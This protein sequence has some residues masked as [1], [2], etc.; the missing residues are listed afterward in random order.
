ME[1]FEH[2]RVNSDRIVNI[3]NKN[4]TAIDMSEMGTGKTYTALRVAS[5]L[6]KPI[7]V[8]CPKSIISTWVKSIIEFGFKQ[9]FNVTN[10]EQI[11]INKDKKYWKPRGRT[12]DW[13]IDDNTLV[14]F[15]EAHRLKSARSKIAKICQ[16]IE[17]KTLLLSATL[18][19]SPLEMRCAGVLLGLFQWNQFF[20]WIQ[21]NGC[22]KNPRFGG[23]VYRYECDRWRDDVRSYAVS[24]KLSSVKDDMKE[25]LIQNQIVEIENLKLVNSAFE[26]YLELKRLESK[27]SAHIEALQYALQQCEL[28]KVNY[29][30][31]RIVDAHHQGYKVIVF[32]T[33]R[34]SQEI[35]FKELEGCCMRSL[36][37]NGSTVQSM[38]ENAIQAFQGDDLDCLLLTYGTCGEGISLDDK[39][40]GNKRMV[41]L[42]PNW[43]AIKMKQALG[44]AYR[45]STKSDVVQQIIF[46]KGTLEEQVAKKV[47]QKLVAI[48]KL[49]ND[50]LF[51]I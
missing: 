28:E 25:N 43:S 41:M 16:R 12:F 4:Q 30:K 31:E 10:Y 33:Y 15:D 32:L 26:K 17:C 6:K 39:L 38:R 20:A 35:L 27:A 46:A 13:I 23:F 18:A 48:D 49:T 3:L 44:R 5:V 29:F 22:Q 45:A 40:G 14:I 19:V 8:V 50:N 34:H 21:L 42:S 2:Q 36:Y 51:E 11:R 9:N 47:K 1:L 7:L 24:T 37:L